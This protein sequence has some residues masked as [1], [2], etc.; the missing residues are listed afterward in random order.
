MAVAAEIEPVAEGVW[1]W[2]VYDPAVKAELFSTALATKAGLYLIDPIPLAT[3]ALARL[4]KLGRIAGIIL[5][6]EN[7][8]RAGCHFAADFRVPIYERELPAEELLGIAIDG[9]AAGEIAILSQ[10]D[11]GTMVVG[12]ALINFEPYGFSLLP[13]KYCSNLKTMRRSLAQ[14]LEYPFDRMLFAHGTPIVRGAR[15]RLEQLLRDR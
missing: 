3:G 4:A 12:D 6:N 8:H 7:H 15:Q 5:T 1:I 14:L 10:S 9:A 11:G 2:R 13:A